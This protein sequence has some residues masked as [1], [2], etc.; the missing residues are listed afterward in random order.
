MLP[1]VLK[2]KGVDHLHYIA[3][4]E[5][6]CLIAAVG[7]FPHNLADRIPHQDFSMRKVQWLRQ[8]RDIPNG[9]T[10][11]DCVPLYFATHTPMQYVWTYGNK[12]GMEPLGKEN[13]VLIEIDAEKVFSQE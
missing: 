4:I 13:F 8:N 3:P 5:N 12:K 9:K 11:H 7:I 6:A 1:A 2:E 10:I